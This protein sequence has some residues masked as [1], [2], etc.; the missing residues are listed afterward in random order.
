MKFKIISIILIIVIVLGCNTIQKIVYD[1]PVTMSE[2]IRIEFSKQC[3]KG[4]ILF[5]INCAKCHTKIVKKREVIPD[6]KP[7]QLK[8]YEL[9]VSNA[10]H[11]S[12]I[13]ETSVSA[14]E[15]GLIMTFLNYKPKTG[16]YV[17]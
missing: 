12:N 9:R 14:E 15:L 13:T 10:N 17:K 6:F 2:S 7:E 3:D 11:E 16:I 4:K 1:F 8:G 5:E